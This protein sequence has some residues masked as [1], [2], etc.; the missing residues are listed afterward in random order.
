[1]KEKKAE[2]VIDTF[3]GPWEKKILRK[4]ALAVPDKVTPDHLTLLGI[5]ATL[6]SAAAYL[7]TWQSRWW[8]FLASFGFVLNWYGD[9]LDGTLARVRHIERE[10][11]GYFV[12]HLADALTTVVICLAFGL[13]P[14]M[15]FEIALMLAIGY[16]LLNV[17][18]HVCAYTH[19]EFRISYM[20]L[21]PTEVR[22]A[23]IIVNTVL[24]FWSGDVLLFRGN[25]LTIM[26]LGGLLFSVAFMA[27]FL[28]MSIKTALNLDKLDRAKKP[29]N[30][31]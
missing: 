2:R 28:V 13:S 22:L 27:I 5:F 18:V 29:G 26:D 12:D 17:Y 23:I 25:Y 16:L 7:L 11:Y 3:T 14:L 31:N 10:R 4:L 30:K 9:S 20:K 6:I 1:M 19:G 24:F 8:L 15:Q 21:G